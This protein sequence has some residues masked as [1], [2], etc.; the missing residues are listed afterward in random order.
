MR[1][2]LATGPQAEPITRG[3]AKDHLRVEV[4]DDDQLIDSLISAA[5]EV[6]EATTQRQLMTATWKLW[7]PRFPLSRYP[8]VL[9]LPPLG[10]VTHV[11]YYD[12]DNA[13]QTWATNQ[14]IVFKQEGPV[15][16][17][18]EIHLAPTLSYPATVTRPDAVEVQYVAGYGAEGAAVPTALRQAMLLLIGHHYENREA[19]NVGNLTTELPLAVKSLLLPYCRWSAATV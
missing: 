4:N 11:K 8:I 19:V 2:S 10:S 7:L 18:S 5:R 16:M 17:E 3:E 12:T 1:L 14:Y 15:A 13:L 9:P 6:V